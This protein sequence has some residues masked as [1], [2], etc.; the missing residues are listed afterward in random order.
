MYSFGGEYDGSGDV[1]DLSN[2]PVN[3][4]LTANYDS[5]H[6]SVDPNR[7][8]QRM[9]LH[10]FSKAPS[11]CVDLSAPA[12]QTTPNPTHSPTSSSAIAIYDSTLGAPKCTSAANFCDSGTLLKSRDSIAGISEPSE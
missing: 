5:T 2:W 8:A 4:T 3:P 10:V 1:N 7:E 11:G 9:F 12:P 6:F